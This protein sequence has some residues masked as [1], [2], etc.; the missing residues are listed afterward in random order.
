M[1]RFVQVGMSLALV[2]SLVAGCGGSGASQ[3]GA[4][5]PAALPRAQAT[6]GIAPVLV[7]ASSDPAEL[8]LTASQA[9]FAAAPVVVLAAAGDES[10]HAAAAAAAL[11]LNAPV[12]LTG[13]AIADSGLAKETA[14]LGARTVVVVTP[15]Q[16]PTKEIA[17]GSVSGTVV[18]SVSA[19]DQ[20]AS[21]RRSVEAID[22][23]LDVVL[24]DAGSLV[25]VP[26]GGQ[27]I[28][29][30]DLADV[31]DD[32][33]ETASP[34]LLTEVLA[35]VDEAPGQTAAVATAQ[36][37]GVVPLVVPGGDPRATSESVQALAAAKALSVVGIGESFGTVEELTTRV[38]SA[39]TGVELAGGGQLVSAGKRFVVL[40]STTVP[41]AP[42]R[43]AEMVERAAALAE[44]YGEVAAAA[45]DATATVATVELVVTESSGT[46]GKDG[47]YST[48]LSVE[49]VRPAV[50]AALD[51]GQQVLLEIQPGRAPFVDQV[52][53][54]ADL[55]ALPGV[56]VSLDLGTRRAGGL[57][58]QDG[59]VPAEEINAV[60]S[61]LSGLVESKALPEKMVVVHASTPRAV[62]NLGALN[63]SDVGVAVVVHS[64]VSG[65][66]ASR[67]AAWGALTAGAPDSLSWG[68]TALSG[69][70]TPER[71]ATTEPIVPSPLLVVVE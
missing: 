37:A 69:E 20:E 50:Q 42:A 68:W 47:N 8:A 61:Y 10:A 28:D 3:D 40:P 63:T 24:L 6:E 15:D 1:V 21:A 22:P 32:L 56:G 2:T 43:V 65:S 26:G 57:V 62:S 31:E 49:A 71:A 13:G 11:E 38:R 55:L 17:A 30:R 70:V 34:R 54:Y 64:D 66:F 33:P 44:P 48:E 35:L 25:E 51:A 5:E 14:R 36:A 60:V 16:E 59:V 58:K 12:L 19:Q 45:G 53:R 9:F 29:E 4:P 39:E 41:T 18:T 27:E 7:L 46:A 23:A 67:S 52:K